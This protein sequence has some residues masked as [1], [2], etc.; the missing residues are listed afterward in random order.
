VVESV[1]PTEIYKSSPLETLKAQAVAARGQVLVKAGTRHRGDPYLYCSE[2][3]C[4]GYGGSQ[5]LNSKTTRA[6]RLTTGL[7]AIDPKGQLVDT[8]YSST[9]GGHTEA[10][11]QMWGGHPQTALMGTQDSGLDQRNPVAQSRLES[12]ITFPP[13]SYC[14]RPSYHFRW[15]KKLKGK[16]LST[17][18]NQMKKIGQVTQINV[19]K[20]GVSGR[21]LEVEYKGTQGQHSVRGSYR[22]R[23]LLGGLKSGLWLVSRSDEETQGEPK[24]WI[25]KGGG[26]GH[27][28]GLCQHGAI[29]MGKAGAKVQAILKHYY[30]GST[31]KK[32]W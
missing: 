25:F 8:V 18:L 24:E 31:L 9:C 32:M 22:N 16:D 20:R 29:G 27:G 4:Q 15:T 23:T 13:A 12:F 7:V 3:H 6:S 5:R 17:A 30:T 28:V 19:L 14:Q 21:A 2:V 1:V 10:Y 26:Y 11:H